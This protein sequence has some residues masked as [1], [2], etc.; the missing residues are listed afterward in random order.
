MKNFDTRVYSINDFL[1]WERNGQLELSPKFQRRSVWSDT[2]R[3]YLMDTII[4][5]KPIPKVFIRQKLNPTTKKSMR[6]VVDGQQRLRTIL[7]YLKDGFQISKRHN[8]KFG[9][10]Y[11]SQLNQV[12]D[13]VQSNL[14]NYEISVDLLVN[15]PDEEVLDIFGRLNSYSVTLNVQEKLNANHFGPFKILAD[16]IAHKYNK[17]WTTNK[18]LSEQNV[19]RMEDI[20][21]VSD[22]LIAMIEGIQT[23]KKIGYYYGEYEKDFSYDIVELESRF[24]ETMLIIQKMFPDTLK[25]SNFNRIHLFYTLFVTIY[26]LQFGLKD[27]NIIQ[28]KISDDE[29]VKVGLIFEKIDEI[30]STEDVRNLSKAESQFLE[31]SRRAT[32]DKSVRVRRTKFILELL[33]ER[34]S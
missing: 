25:L 15:I 23:K 18:I 8:D 19:L 5:G 33:V 34:W 10:L 27:M 2:A 30:F 13:E 29:I 9:G 11:Y 31:D 28:R 24:D 14:L 17:F 7:S 12:D 21:L 1:E 3:S 4:S 16:K 22:L 26:H 6:E 20:Y 32:T